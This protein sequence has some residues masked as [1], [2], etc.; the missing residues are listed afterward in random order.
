[1]SNSSRRRANT[2]SPRKCFV[3]LAALLATPALV[4]AQGAGA[5]GGQVL[6]F[7]AGARAA[8]FS[9]AY[10]A[11]HGDADAL[12]Y[13][14]AGIA[15]LLRGAALSYESYV[16]DIGL[17]SFGGAYTM[18]RFSFGLGGVYLDEGEVEE[19]VADPDFGGNRC[20][21]TGRSVSASESVIRLSLARPFGQNLRMGASAG[22]V[23][24]SLADDART[25]PVLDL[26]A[27]YELPFV[28]LGI[29]L[30]N[31]GGS[32][33][34]DSLTDAKLPGEARLG[35]AF[36]LIQANGIVINVQSDLVARVRESSAG[37]LAGVEA[38]WLA[39]TSRPVGAVAR[40]GYDAANGQGG[41][42]SLKLGLGM[43]LDELA[44]DYAYQHFE[45]L[46]AVHRFGLRWTVSR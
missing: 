27:Q 3:V 43:T 31:L 8:A 29:A 44:F 34:S 25:A 12:F 16:E 40:I 2:F 7:V 13:N 37:L 38:G 9:G 23:S 11:G 45:S 36:R 35:A 4:I 14:P 33:S 6:Q 20:I 15:A 24:A 26:G 1:M 39:S 41:L 17:T 19:C 5:T 42:G 46:G 18:G 10:T 28:T 21:A 32:L 30:R 22:L